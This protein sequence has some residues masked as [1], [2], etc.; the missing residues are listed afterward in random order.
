L[1]TGS[2]LVSDFR[3]QPDIRGLAD[4]ASFLTNDLG[5]AAET[6]HW[7]AAATALEAPTRT[8]TEYLIVN[9]TKFF[10]AACQMKARLAFPLIH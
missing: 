8:P 6:V 3:R 10:T 1:K 2:G 5:H 9:A 7:Q 4:A